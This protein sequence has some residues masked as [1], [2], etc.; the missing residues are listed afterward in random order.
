MQTPA[1]YSIGEAGQ[2]FPKDWLAI[3]F[4]PSFPH[5]LV[6]IVQAAY[7]SVAFVRAAVAA[8]SM[9]HLLRDKSEK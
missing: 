4:N 2:F 5:R 8:V 9:L 3:I 7:L 6:H 1:G